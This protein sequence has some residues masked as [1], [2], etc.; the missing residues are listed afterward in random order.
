MMKN[1]SFRGWKEV[2]SFTFEQNVKAKGFKRSLII[3]ASV[4]FII[5]FA[6]NIIIGYVQND[7]KEKKEFVNEIEKL[8][9]INDTEMPNEVIEGY[10]S[11]SEYG[12]EMSVEIVDKKVEE[13]VDFE[14]KDNEKTALINVY[15]DEKYY[16]D[17]ENDSEEGAAKEDG[18][19][20]D[21]SA[22]VID[23]YTTEEISKKNAVK[24]GNEFGE[25]FEDNKY[26]LTDVSKEAA[27]YLSLDYTENIM[28]IQESDESVGEMIMKMLVPMIVVM[29]VYFIILVY[30][31]SIGKILVV[32]KDSKLMETLLISVKPYAV[33]FGKVLA[34]YVV[35][36]FQS[37]LW[38]LSAVIGFVSGHYV[39]KIL[40]DKYNNPV[41]EV[42]DLLSETTK[43][44]FSKSAII[45]GILAFL[46]G[47]L[48][49]FTIA[50]LI[51]SN[52]SKTEELTNGMAIFQMIVIIGF[53]ASYFIPLMEIENSV[54]EYI[55]YIP[56]IAP[57]MVPADVIVG[58]MGIMQGVISIAIMLVTGF[59]TIVLTGKI[60]K[61]KVF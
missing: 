20:K 37:V 35:A 3:V 16:E 40:F 50:A 30:G 10:A 42:M 33:V 53:F 27:V 38:I 49:Y 44:A 54:T 48:V 11:A 61:K 39:T 47:I 26:L 46:I 29:I 12:A 25:Y 32:E 17:I 13:A 1:G 24:I 58:N 52:A 5:A 6:V 18:E 2:F 28:D 14:N 4:L 51:A 22:F 34:M 60:Y 56:I 55:R 36:V 31:Q 19:K 8:V 45:L 7:K 41:L 21:N 57:Y 15:Y 9:I 59:V 23:I 43:S